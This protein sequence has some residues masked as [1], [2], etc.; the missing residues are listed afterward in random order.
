MTLVFKR[1]DSWYIRYRSPNGKDVRKRVPAKTKREAEFFLAKELSQIDSRIDEFIGSA[2]EVMFFE[3]CED[4]LTYGRVHK[5]SWARDVEHVHKLKAYFGDVPARDIKPAQV[6]EYIA[7]RR[8][9]KKPTGDLLAPATINRELACLRTIYN[10]AIRNEKLEKNPVRHIR[11]LKEN[12]KRDR[13][14]SRSEFE[15]LL[16]QSADH[17]KAIMITAYETGMRAGEIFNLDWTQVD[18]E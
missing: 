12:N 9:R 18:L 8:R 15:R 7:H 16:E 4:F 10:R 17:L 5:R 13:I 11:F 14:L 6:E 3:I 1:A 2:R